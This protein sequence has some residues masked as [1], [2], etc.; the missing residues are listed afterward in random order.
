MWYAV[1]KYLYPICPVMNTTLFVNSV[2]NLNFK[3]KGCLLGCLLVNSVYYNLEG[4]LEC[5]NLSGVTKG[6]F[7]LGNPVLQSYRKLSFL[8][9]SLI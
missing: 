2:L 8:N 4:E 3:S 9:S 5:C 7:C 1:R 6:S